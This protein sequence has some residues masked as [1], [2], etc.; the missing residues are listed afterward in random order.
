MSE[1]TFTTADVAKHRD[2]EN[3]FWLIVENNVYDVTSAFLPL[4]PPCP[5]PH[6]S[7][8]FP[9]SPSQ[10]VKALPSSENAC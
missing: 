2:E 10:A 7:V 9:R 1:Q 6:P 4:S 8:A 3:G 5:A